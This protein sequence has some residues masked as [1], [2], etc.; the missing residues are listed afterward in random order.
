MAKWRTNEAAYDSEY[1]ALYYPWI[2]IT[3]LE[4]KPFML[5]PCGHI[6]GIY[7]R[8]DGERG[9]HEA[10][11]NEVVRGA[12]DVEMQ[13]TKEEQ[14]LL[15]PMGV[16]CIRTF[17]GRGIRVWGARL[18]SSDP[19]WRYVNVRRLFNYVEESIREGTQWARRASGRRRRQ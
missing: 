13:I 12:L 9:V 5:P 17:P 11:A 18:L 6:A 7:A 10:P 8:V 14:D 2:E 4:G 16:N 3:D 19:A 15:N 1:A